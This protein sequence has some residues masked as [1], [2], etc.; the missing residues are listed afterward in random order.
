MLR[1]ADATQSLQLSKLALR[2]QQAR[3]I[4]RALQGQSSLRVLDLSGNRL[5]D[6]GC[7]DLARVLKLL[8]CLMVLNLSENEITYKGLQHFADE[9]ENTSCRL[10]ALKNL[11]LS[12]NF[13]TDNCIKFLAK[14]ISYLPSLETLKLQSCDL[15]VRF[16]QTHR[17]ALAEAFRNLHCFENLDISHNNIGPT[18]VQL[19]LMCLKPEGE[20]HLNLSGVTSLTTS[21]HLCRY[22]SQYAVQPNCN[23]SQLNLSSCH[24]QP[25]SVENLLP[26]AKRFHSLNLS[27]NPK[28]GAE[29][30]RIILD[31]CSGGAIQSL[32]VSNCGISVDTRLLTSLG[33]LLEERLLMELTVSASKDELQSLC[34]V[35]RECY[36]HQALFQ[37]KYETQCFMSVLDE[38]L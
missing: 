23:L 7:Q 29:G 35:W 25:Q 22:I 36:K 8:D 17:M 12:F 32:D 13:L 21:E 2:L 26:C 9:L 24:L 6:E 4:I 16:F 1:K 27:M 11:N 10:Q 5:G 20:L 3:P 34:D 15:T 19:L 14:F 33:S 30:V 28:L 38:R 37:T 31:A 18:G